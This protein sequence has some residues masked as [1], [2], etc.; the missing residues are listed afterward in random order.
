MNWRYDERYSVHA[1]YF[2]NRAD[3]ASR[4]SGEASW[5]TRFTS[6]GAQLAFDNEV[7]VLAQYMTGDT[8]ID[9]GS[10]DIVLDYRAAYVLASKTLGRHR[11]SVRGDWFET[12]H[13]GA[14]YGNDLSEDGWAATFAYSYAVRPKQRL[15]LELLEIDSFREARETLDHEEDV[16]DHQFQVGY[17]LFF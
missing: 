6:L 4:E 5:L 13:L 1:L 10:R 11:L 17:R 12:T 15:F 7:T 3:P 9:I 14:G 8:L 2:D 16:R